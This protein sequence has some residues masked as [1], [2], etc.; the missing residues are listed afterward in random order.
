MAQGSRDMNEPANTSMTKPT[1][2]RQHRKISHVGM[3]R[4]QTDDDSEDRGE[5]DGPVRWSD[6]CLR[7]GRRRRRRKNDARTWRRNEETGL[8][9]G[10][11]GGQYDWHHMGSKY[12]GAQTAKGYF[13]P[14]PDRADFTPAEKSGYNEFS[15]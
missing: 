14:G 15:G 6:G 12:E 7:G 10:G 4:T 2:V 8:I 5:L 3:A 11:G 1:N 13:I 9:S